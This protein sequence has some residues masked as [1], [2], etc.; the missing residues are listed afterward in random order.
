M[1]MGANQA[2]DDD[3]TFQASDS[4]VGVLAWKV[5][6]LADVCYQSVSDEDG[7]IGDDLPRG[8]NGDDDC[9]GVEHGCTAA[10]MGPRTPSLTA[11]QLHEGR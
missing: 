7:A 4:L 5:V 8:I 6:G 11:L 3:A 2:R 10:D 9:V 1:H